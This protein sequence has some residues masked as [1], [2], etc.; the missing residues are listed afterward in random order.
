[1]K[2]T[3]FP[4]KLD[5]LLLQAALLEGQQ[6]LSAWNKWVNLVD[7]NQI[8]VASQKLLPLVLQNLKRQGISDPAMDKMKGIHRYIWV[9]N[10]TSF[11]AYLPLFEEL[12]LRQIPFMF[13][14]GTALLF[15]GYSDFGLRGM[16][17]IDILIPEEY[18]SEVHRILLQYNIR[19]KFLKFRAA[20]AFSP[21]LLSV[22]N[23]VAFVKK[24]CL[25]L[26]LHWK[27]LINNEKDITSLLW[28]NSQ[29][30]TAMGI[31]F[32]IPKP[33][34]LF[35]HVCQHGVDYNLEPTFRWIADAFILQKAFL[36]FSWDTV[37]NY[38]QSYQEESSMAHVLLYLKKTFRIE[39]PLSLKAEESLS[40]LQ[41]IAAKPN[42]RR[43]S[44]LK[45]LWSWH[46][47]SSRKSI[48]Y[49]LATFPR[50]VSE[51]FGLRSIFHLIPYSFYLCFFVFYHKKIAKS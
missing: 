26:D 8:T 35:F 5:E 23:G 7:I 48:S 22:V 39:C 37:R 33:E 34:A 51:F 20:R 50:F 46:K 30:I 28:E 17:D 13:L 44:A 24:D 1:M 16:Q 2:N 45:T 14:K 9:K 40:Y 41:R 49:R 15:C 21:G 3:S 29:Q 25:E 43:I 6:A 38:A 4:K 18:I 32:Y 11:H 10:T 47:Q 42:S 12:N 27:V 36:D 19:C 31:S